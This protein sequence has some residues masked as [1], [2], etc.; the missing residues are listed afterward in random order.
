M[1]WAR[2]VAMSLCCVLVAVG[3]GFVIFGTGCER[4][5]FSVVVGSIW[6]QYGSSGCSRDY[7]RGWGGGGCLYYGKGILEVTLPATQEPPHSHPVVAKLLW[8]LGFRV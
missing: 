4:A 2:F 1:A 3:S 8:G 5:G 7:F 6:L